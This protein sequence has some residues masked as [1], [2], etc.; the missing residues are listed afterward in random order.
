MILLT[1][2][3]ELARF[4]SLDKLATYVGLIPDT[5]VA[6]KPKHMGHLTFRR[7]PQLRAVLIEAAWTACRKDP[8]LLL[9]FNDYCKR[10]T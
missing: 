2:L 8:V 1:E 5:Q 6:G 7:N 10:M 9:A 4:A 3:C